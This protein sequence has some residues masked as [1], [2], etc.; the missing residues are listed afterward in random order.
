M[1]TTTD[2]DRVAILAHVD[3]IFRAYFRNDRETIRRTHTEDWRGFH[4]RSRTIVRGVDEYMRHADEVLRA[5]RG[6]RYEMLDTD[7]RVYGDVAVVFYLAREW[8]G[9]GSGTE[10]TILLRACDVYRRDG[11]AWN[12]C[13]SNVY[14]MPDVGAGGS[15]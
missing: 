4:L 15:G 2:N 13:G 9:D 8:I 10:K 12:Q 5:I 6:L 11:G 7:V 14:V 3:S 1:D